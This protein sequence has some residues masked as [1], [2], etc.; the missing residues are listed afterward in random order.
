M[1]GILYDF[2]SNLRSEANHYFQKAESYSFCYLARVK[3][4]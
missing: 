4:K 3:E 1:Q 2:F